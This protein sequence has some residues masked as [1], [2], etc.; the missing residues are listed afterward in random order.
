MD[1]EKKTK[2]NINFR[3]DLAH[4]GI[5]WELHPTMIEEGKYT[6]PYACYTMSSQEKHAFCQFLVDLKVPDGYSSNISRC[7]DV[8]GGKIWDEMSW[9]SCISTSLSPSFN[10]WCSSKGSLWSLNWT[11][12]FFRELCSKTLSLDTL[13]LLE[14]TIVLTLCKIEK[15][16][17]PSFFWHNGPFTHSLSKWG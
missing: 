9:L 3:F 15:I 5:R 1:L 16:F 4:M 17:P 8:E 12:S 13:Y 10:S 11:W 6:F 2:D 14:K 7:I